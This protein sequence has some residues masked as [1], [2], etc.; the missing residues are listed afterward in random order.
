M[1]WS[2]YKRHNS[3][4]HV[5]Y[6]AFDAKANA[7]MSI[8]VGYEWDATILL[9]QMPK[10]IPFVPKNIKDIIERAWAEF[11]RSPYETREPDDLDPPPK[12]WKNVVRKYTTAIRGAAQ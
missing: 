10:D 8:G 2:E 6:A 11:N 9:P 3:V 5:L 7:E 4:D 1:L 12:N